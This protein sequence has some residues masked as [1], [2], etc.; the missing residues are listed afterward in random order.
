MYCGNCR[1]DIKMVKRCCETCGHYMQNGFDCAH[2][3]DFGD[4]EMIPCTYWFEGSTNENIIYRIRELE[5]MVV[6]DD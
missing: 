4:Q 6:E 3:G 2:W 5:K 1:G